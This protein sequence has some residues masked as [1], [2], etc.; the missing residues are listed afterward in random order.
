MTPIV[1]NNKL[2][3]RW[4]LIMRKVVSFKRASRTRGRVMPYHS[5]W[6]KFSFSKLYQILWNLDFRHDDGDDKDDAG[7]G[8]SDDDSDDND[9]GDD[10]GDVSTMNGKK[11]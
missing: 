4:K 8:D 3:K 6:G 11:R 9:D 10:D 1:Q 2:P 5:P 7:D